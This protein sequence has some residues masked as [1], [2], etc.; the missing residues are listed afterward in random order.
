MDYIHELNNFL[1]K[2]SKDISKKLNL[3]EIKLHFFQTNC[4]RSYLEKLSSY[5]Y[6][7]LVLNPG[8]WSHTSLA[9]AD[10]LE[11]INIPYIE[12]HISNIYNRE[13]YRKKSFVSKG[14]TGTISGLGFHSYLAAIFCILKK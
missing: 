5:P 1:R 10:R 2:E 13:D 6:N 3:D 7:G 14:A 12:V 4:K 11:A 8:A 9:L